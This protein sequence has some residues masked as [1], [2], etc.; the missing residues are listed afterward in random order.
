M[1]STNRRT[2]LKTTAAAGAAAL[3]LPAVHAAGSDTLKLGI[4]GV[5]G[6]GSSAVGD[7]MHADP[8]VTL[9]AA[10]DVF[11]D[12][13]ESGVRSLKQAFGDRVAI[14]ADRMHTG[15]DGYKAVIDSDVDVV[16]LATSPGFRPLH[17]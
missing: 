8:N 4:V 5:G 10:C 2:F 3:T 16:I 14:P 12:R 11:K 6:R 15:F 13:L 9:V 1:S 17:F 7:S